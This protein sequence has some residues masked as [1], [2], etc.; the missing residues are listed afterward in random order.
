MMVSV[1]VFM[2][3]KQKNKFDNT[4]VMWMSDT[5]VKNYS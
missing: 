4:E 3:S 1:Q 5:E 2:R